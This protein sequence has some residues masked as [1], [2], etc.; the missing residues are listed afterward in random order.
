[1]FGVNKYKCGM[2]ILLQLCFEIYIK[3]NN[4]PEGQIRKENKLKLS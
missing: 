3:Y 4:M 2:Q 1:M